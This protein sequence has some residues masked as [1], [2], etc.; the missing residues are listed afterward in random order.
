M[1]KRKNLSY[2]GKINLSCKEWTRREASDGPR[3]PRSGGSDCPFFADRRRRVNFN[4]SNMLRN[5]RSAEEPSSST[6]WHQLAPLPLAPRPIRLAARTHARRRPPHPPGRARTYVRA[7]QV[8]MPPRELD[9]RCT[10]RGFFFF[11]PALFYTRTGSD[12][13]RCHLGDRDGC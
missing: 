7:R 13:S 9:I 4:D 10:R 8:L 12:V 6:R 1:E 5:H 2:K 3:R 11:F